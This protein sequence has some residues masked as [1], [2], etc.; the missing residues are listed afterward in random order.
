[1]ATDTTTASGISPSLSTAISSNGTAAAAVDHLDPTVTPAGTGSTSPSI[2][3]AA[4]G[5]R[6]RSLTHGLHLSV[7]ENLALGFDAQ[8]D[9]TA[10]FSLRISNGRYTLAVENRPASSGIWSLLQDVTGSDA[11]SSVGS[12]PRLGVAPDGSA[13]IAFQYVHYAAPNTLDVNAVTRSGANGSWTAVTDVVSGGASSAPLDAGMSPTDKGYILYSFQ[14]TNSGLDCMGAVRASAGGAFSSPQCVSAPNF[15]FSNGALTFLGNDAYMVWSGQPNG[16][17]S[18]VVEGSAW[19]D[20]AAAPETFTDLDSPSTTG[21]GLDA[22]V[23]DQD[24]SV[25]GFWY[26]GSGPLRDSAFDAG[27]PN[28]ISSSIPTA[29]VVGKPVSMD[30]S[31][32][33]LWSPPVSTPTWSFG[34]GSSGSERA[35][36]TP[37]RHRVTTRSRSPPPTRSAMPRPLPTRSPSVPARRPSRP[38]RRRRPPSSKTSRSP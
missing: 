32:V 10:A 22:L 2:R 4:R 15:Q 18:S 14:G 26:T 16:G 24:G 3:P 36:P 30:A 29:G 31:F 28:V 34:D 11:T 37:S 19:I 35:S 8:G 6:P 21:F 25:V 33:D 27:G 13:V 20:G 23:P 17:T 9:L 1:M 38:S 5:A 12:P 7:E